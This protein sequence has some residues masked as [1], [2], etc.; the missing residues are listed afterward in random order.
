MAPL[1]PATT[2]AAIAEQLREHIAAAAQLDAFRQAVLA[3]EPEQ[4]A[5]LTAAFDAVW[6][7][8]AYLETAL[9]L[10][11]VKEEGALFSRLKAALPAGDRQID[12]MVA[13]HDLIRMK[14]DD[15][16]SAILDLLEGHDGLRADAP[17]LRT[18]AER[19]AD[20]VSHPEPLAERKEAAAAL[21][22]GERPLRERGGAG[23]SAGPAPARRR[24][25]GPHRRRDSAP[26]GVGGRPAMPREPEPHASATPST[27]G[28]TVTAR[29][30][31]APV[32]GQGALPT[33][34]V[35]I[36][37]APAI[38]VGLLVALTRAAG[39]SAGWG[40][41]WR[42]LAQVHGQVM[43]AGW[44]GLFVIDKAGRL[45]LAVAQ[46]AAVTCMGVWGPAARLRE[47][48]RPIALLLRCA[49]GWLAVTALLLAYGARGAAGAGSALAL[50]LAAGLGNAPPVPRRASAAWRTDRPRRRY[51][52][53]LTVPRTGRG[54]AGR[55]PAANQALRP[56]AVAP[57]TPVPARRQTAPGTRHS[58]R[59]RPAPCAARR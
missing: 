55:T 59:P 19:A 52:P 10:H 9:E 7:T 43:T 53:A 6:R 42:A 44:A 48:A 41:R 40:L 3:A 17:A 14:G 36:A 25:P 11:I 39:L 46:F 35:L 21:V 18:L 57:P 29:T 47:N 34:A 56:V 23:L 4:P 33:V 22:E 49:Y 1:I 13:E 16:R 26:A 24:D 2:P 27:A 37:A 5:S 12:E 58:A 30:P 15:V 28:R 31:P 51:Q 32:A 20:G 38:G 50:Q 45:L 54:G 8:L